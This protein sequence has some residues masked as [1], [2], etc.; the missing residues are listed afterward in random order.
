MRSLPL[1]LTLVLVVAP[2]QA[3]STDDEIDADGCPFSTTEALCIVGGGV[4]IGLG[5]FF[6]PLMCA[7]VPPDVIVDDAADS[8]PLRAVSQQRRGV[9]LAGA[10]RENVA[11]L[12]AAEASPPSRGGALVESASRLLRER[13]A[14]RPANN[15]SP[16]GQ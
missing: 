4:A 1:L 11:S 12:R 16:T 14:C 3:Q 7:D 9:G 5:F 15:A 6:A 13:E 2:I 10:S 8:Q